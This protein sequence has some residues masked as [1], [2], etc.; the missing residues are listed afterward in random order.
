MVGRLMPSGTMPVFVKGALVRR[1]TAF[2]TISIGQPS[3]DRWVI[4]AQASFSSGPY[5]SSITPPTVGGV[6]ASTIVNS[7]DNY[8]DD[9]HR[10]GVFA[11]RVPGGTTVS[12][13]AGSGTDAVGIWTLTGVRSPLTSRSV[14]TSTSVTTALPACAVGFFVTN[15]SDG[16]GVLSVSNMSLLPTSEAASRVAEDIDIAASPISYTV[17]SGP[18]DTVVLQTKVIFRF[19]Y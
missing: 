14:T 10:G 16:G 19:D 15:F 11:A 12:V 2:G 17:S 3:E 5:S 7:V 4:I 6:T 1:A 9:G 13:S 8:S 18:S